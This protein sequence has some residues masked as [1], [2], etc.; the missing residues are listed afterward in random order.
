MAATACLLLELPPD[1]WQDIASYLPAPDLLRYLSSHRLLHHLAGSASFWQNISELQN[2]YGKQPEEQEQQE[3]ATAAN[4]NSHASTLSTT[5]YTTTAADEAAAAKAAKEQ[6]L[7]AAYTTRLPSVMWRRVRDSIT[8]PSAREGHAA[9]VLMVPGF[10][11]KVMIVTGGFTADRGIYIKNLAGNATNNND[12]RD[13]SRLEPVN[14]PGFTYGATLTPVVNKEGAGGVYCNS[15]ILFG[16]FRSGG[17]SGETHQ[18]AALELS[19]TTA[20]GLRAVWKGIYCSVQ[21]LPGQLEANVDDHAVA[22]GVRRVLTSLVA[23]A[24][25]TATLLKHR[26]LLIMGGM[27]AR[28]SIMNPILLDT[29]TWTWMNQVKIGPVPGMGYAEPEPSGRHGHSVVWDG[30]RNRLVLFGGGNGSDLLRSGKDNSEV[31]ELKRQTTQMK[32]SREENW[33]QANLLESFPWWEW[34]LLHQDQ[35]PGDDDGAQQFEQQ[36][37]EAE[38]AAMAEQE[39]DDDDGDISAVNVVDVNQLAPVET[40][41]LGRLHVGVKVS[42]DTVVFAF[43]S[44]RPSTNG[45]LAYNLET[46]EFFR[47]A[48]SGPL[49]TPRFTAASVMV[50]QDGYLFV[51]GGYSSQHG[52]AVSDMCILDMAPAL[53][54]DSPIQ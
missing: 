40:L 17:Y 23:R 49:P 2:G 12:G 50:E 54:R 7:L 33:L 4:S 14:S 21:S 34:R 8:A 24:Y 26:Y 46:D 25:H 1:A 45:V 9:C 41:N 39:G 29:H 20:T 31:W 44:G 27:K 30:R 28:G 32:G 38:N 19:Y 10:S 16:G 22:H 37:R 18:V 36:Q 11:D 48:L 6:F 35:N 5:T 42:P 47:P 43:G 13:W 53:R 51:H 52:G 15:A 3:S